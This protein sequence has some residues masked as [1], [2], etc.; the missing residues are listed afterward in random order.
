MHSLNILGI[1]LIVT[2]FVLQ[3]VFLYAGFKTLLEVARL[4]F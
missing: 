4:I 3:A 1:G 2:V